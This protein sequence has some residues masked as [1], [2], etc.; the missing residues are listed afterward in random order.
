MR[1]WAIKRLQLTK[2]AHVYPSVLQRLADDA[3]T[4]LSIGDS[5]S[6]SVRTRG[7]KPVVQEAVAALAKVRQRISQPYVGGDP[8]VRGTSVVMVLRPRGR[9]DGDDLTAPAHGPGSTTRDPAHGQDR[10]A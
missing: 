1:Q 8:E 5:V 4:A 9:G 7:A 10:G 6:I 2:P 3:D